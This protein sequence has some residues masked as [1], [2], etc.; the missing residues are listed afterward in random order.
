MNNKS[1][2]QSKTSNKIARIGQKNKAKSENSNLQNASPI[3]EMELD[4]SQTDGIGFVDGIKGGALYGWCY[5]GVKGKLE[6][7]H[8]VINDLVVGQVIADQFRPDL[9][10]AGYNDGICAFVWKIPKNY[11]EGTENIEIITVTS[12]GAL[13]QNSP[14]ILYGRKFPGSIGDDEYKA[15]VKELKLGALNLFEGGEFNLAPTAKLNMQ[16][17]ANV[18][19]NGWTMFCTSSDTSSISFWV[20]TLENYGSEI[21]E[22]VLRVKSKKPVKTLHIFG[23]FV[24]PN[25]Y[26]Y[27]P[28]TL[29]FVLGNKNRNSFL[30]AKIKV[31]TRD[32]AGKVNS[33]YSSQVGQSSGD[34]G[35]FS[36]NI[37]AD[38][39]NLLPFDNSTFP[40]I[41]FEFS[42][43]IDFEIGKFSLG[44]G[45]ASKAI[46]VGM[47]DGFEDANIAKQFD[48]IRG[49]YSPQK[50]NPN[51]QS[52]AHKWRNL[53]V[54]VLP[55]I[56]VPIYDALDY[57]KDCLESILQNTHIPYLLT[58]IDDGSLPEV[59]EWLDQFSSNKPWI[60][61]IHNYKNIGYT[62]SINRA[63]RESTGKSLVLLNSDTIV[64]N[65]WLEKLISAAESDSQIGVVGPM[66]NAASWQSL[67][68]IKDENGNWAINQLSAGVS[69]NEYAEKLSI[70]SDGNYLSV[71]VLNG[72]CL[73]VKRSV[74]NEIGLFDESVFP[75][76]Y[77][78]ENDFCFRA[79][80]AGY[81]LR[82]VTNAYVFHAKTKSFGADRRKNLIA[83]ANKILNERYGEDRFIALEKYFTEQ[84]LLTEL[85]KKM[86]LEVGINA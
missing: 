12:A 14:T 68:K 17:G 70:V 61:V 21:V 47:L 24:R 62:L 22:T 37:P 1:Q 51:D 7:V 20:S 71:P 67:P 49:F 66:S 35:E 5:S 63:I 34:S 58:L 10:D 45:V 59:G 42:G 9:R 60:K 6:T 8:F 26:F 65:G 18:V 41:Q 2:N 85:R 76:G 79:V 46:S 44:Y 28:L 25:F 64:S 33:H 53:S 19:T 43:L 16:K 4:Y 48:S 80:D 23:N 13:L 56:I 11:L 75:D 31:I 29:S 52:S 78:E 74:F 30:F 55:E 73:Y 83:K 86:A 54:N 57:V 72:F 40:A 81:E 39:I 36:I 32:P 77:G 3:R 50:I 84:S 82:L 15:D 27:R 38:V 69:V